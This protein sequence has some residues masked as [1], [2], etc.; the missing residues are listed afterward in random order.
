MKRYIAGSLV[1]AVVLAAVLALWSGAAGQA[2]AQPTAVPPGAEPGRKP[3]MIPVKEERPVPKLP[4][5]REVALLTLIIESSD[6]GDVKSVK[7]ERAKIIQSY[8]PNVLGRAGQW[9]VEVAGEKKTVSFGVIDPRLLRIY[10]RGERKVPHTT[11]LQTKAVWELVVPL[12]DNDQDL[13]AREIRIV[14]E[15]KRELF[16]TRVERDS[17]LK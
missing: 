13:G 8:A 15:N 4:D 9:T 1:L 6:N 14:D 5:R 3:T 10:E 16:K 17:W 7:L 12:W 11:Q 2:Q